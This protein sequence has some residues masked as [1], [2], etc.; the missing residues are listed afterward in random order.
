M[1]SIANQLIFSLTLLAAIGCVKPQKS[2]VQVISAVQGISQGEITYMQ[3]EDTI[4]TAALEE[5]EI[6]YDRI[7]EQ[8]VQIHI[9]D[10]GG[11]TTFNEVPSKYINLDA[12]LEVSRN[13]FQD[14]F[15]EKWSPM[16]GQQYTTIYIKSKQD[17]QVFYVKS[18]FTNSEK[19]IGRYSEDF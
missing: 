13:V 7:A 11:S 5:G 2:H 1:K 8:D 9:T 18:V 6:N 12:T 10:A 3:G 19:E 17:N 14:Y 16:K 4:T 15:P